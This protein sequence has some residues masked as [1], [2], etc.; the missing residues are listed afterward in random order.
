MSATKKIKS[1][2]GRGRGTVSASR[3]PRSVTRKSATTALV[4]GGSSGAGTPIAGGSKVASG[5]SIAG[6]FSCIFL[7]LCS[8][9]SL[10]FFLACYCHC[11]RY[12]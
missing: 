6:R 3:T 8:F 9:L 7:L 5:A 11:L 2:T 4:A 1:A 10:S 12:G